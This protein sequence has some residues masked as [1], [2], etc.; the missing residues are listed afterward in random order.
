[1]QDD[2]R[3]HEQVNALARNVVEELPDLITAL[4]AD[5]EVKVIVFASAK[6]DFIVGADIN[7]FK[8]LAA[9]GREGVREMVKSSHPVF[10]MMATGKP[11][12]AAINGSCLGG[13]AE[14]ALSC[15]YRYI[16]RYV[17]VYIEAER[18]AERRAEEAKAEQVCLCWRR[19]RS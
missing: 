5:P 3:M 2:G 1:M 11:K 17:C 8:E 4:E 16:C 7:M 19:Q 14:F 12:I 13:G 10:D 15:H 9:A 6:K 18:R